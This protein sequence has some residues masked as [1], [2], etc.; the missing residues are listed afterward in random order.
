MSSMLR[1]AVR[2]HVA[3]LGH[4]FGS[5]L[6]KLVCMPSHSPYNALIQ[7]FN[8]LKSSATAGLFAKDET[9]LSSNS[10]VP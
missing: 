8:R 4:Q 10:G 9:E 1:D 3:G 7:P 5:T 2:D 6:R